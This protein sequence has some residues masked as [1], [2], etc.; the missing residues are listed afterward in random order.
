MLHVPHVHAGRARA[1]VQLI[2]AHLLLVG[3]EG[4][5]PPPELLTRLA[6]GRAGGVVLFARNVGSPSETAAAVRVIGAA[7]ERTPFVT[8]DQEGGRVQ[9][10]KEPLTRW[11][12]MARLGALDDLALTESV[13][14]AM[15]EELRLVGIN[16]DL[17]PVL[18]VLSNPA[19]PV[20]GDRA[21]GR[22]AESVARHALA[23]WRGLESA[24]VLGCGKH[25][26]GHGDT[27]QDSHLELPRLDFDRA[28]LDAVELPPFRA[29]I[30]GGARLLMTAHVVFSAIDAL[31]ATLS[32][33]WLDGVLRGELG[34]RGVIVSDDLDMKA[35][36]GR[37][38]VAEVIERGLA[39]GV[40]LFLACRDPERQREAEEALLRAADDPVL[41]PRVAASLGR[42]SALRDQLAPA[43]PVDQAQLAAA[44]P[45]AAHQALAAR[46][47]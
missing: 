5:V 38:P 37:F 13:G 25:F 33:P 31:P 19:N 10:L 9:R 16:V 30:A 41:G 4:L 2:P 11:P 22:D 43:V 40:D 20:I 28:R 26:P 45:D 36:A 7:C 44:L 1:A 32:T 47:A 35:V 15:G 29:A 21:F 24:G 39:A 46:F 17:A 14:R 12:P 8:V 27:A 3:Y 34:Y 23:W 42:V 18:D 6:A